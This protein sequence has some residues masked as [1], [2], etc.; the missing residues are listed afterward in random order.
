METES[1]VA[2]AWREACA[3]N[4]TVEAAWDRLHRALREELGFIKYAA[5]RAILDLADVKTVLQDNEMTLDELLM[6]RETV[7]AA[8]PYW[9]AMIAYIQDHRHWTP[10]AIW[11]HYK[12]LRTGDLLNEATH[13]LDAAQ[14]LNP[15]H[16]AAGQD[17]IIRELMPA[18]TAEESPDP[19]SDAGTGR[20]P[21][22]AMVG[23][24]KD[25]DPVPGTGTDSI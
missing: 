10:T 24:T 2:Q 17:A 15:G 20:A 19:E 4:E 23:P 7:R 9:R 21:D 16:A 6:D 13:Y 18:S 1:K 14:S 8:L 11:D 3:A 22:R 25:P 5:I 12:T